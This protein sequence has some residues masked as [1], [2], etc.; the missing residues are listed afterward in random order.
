MSHVKNVNLG[1]SASGNL[2]KGSLQLDL[3]RKKAPKRGY[4]LTVANPGKSNYLQ[5]DGR[6]FGFMVPGAHTQVT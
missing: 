5:L 2:L 6:Y 3:T 1:P 4:S